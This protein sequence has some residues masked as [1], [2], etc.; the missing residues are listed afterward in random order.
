[1]T[2]APASA[3]W[4]YPDATVTS[5]SAARWR[6]E[7]R[8]CGGPL[9]RSALGAGR[10]HPPSEPRL[11]RVRLDGLPDG[12]VG[13]DLL[14]AAVDGRDLVA[15]VEGL[16]DTA[17]AALRHAAAA[18]DLHGIVRHKVG[19]PRDG[20]LQERDAPADLGGLRA[21]QVHLVRHLVQHR[22]AHLDAGEVLRQLLADNG[23][24]RQCLAEHLPLHGPF[25]DLLGADAGAR[26]APD[27]DHPALVVKVRHDDLE[28]LVLLDE[29]VPF[30]HHGALVGDEGS[31]CGAGVL[32]L[33]DLRLHRVVAL[34]QEHGDAPCAGAAG[35]HRGHEVV[36]VH[37]ASDPLLGAV[38]DVVLSRRVQHGGC[39]QGRDVAPS[40]RLADGQAARLLPAEDG[41]EE[42]VLHPRRAVLDDHRHADRVGRVH[43]VLPAWAHQADAFLLDHQLVEIIELLRRDHSTHE[44]MLRVLEMLAGPLAHGVDAHL[45]RLQ[46]E[47]RV[48]RRTISLACHGVLIH[49]LGPPLAK[50]FPKGDVGLFEVW[51]VHSL[52]VRG[53]SV[54]HGAE[55]FLLFGRR[56]QPMLEA[57]HVALHEARIL[58]QHLVPVQREEILR[59]VLA[60]V[61]QQRHPAAGVHLRELGDIVDG[62]VH[63]H[64]SILWGVV[65]LHLLQSEIRSHDAWKI[66]NNLRRTLACCK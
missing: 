33:D 65:L 61:V 9:V 47:V 36:R 37:A 46:S 5:A 60:R 52:Q 59:R 1:M 39:A 62:A 44:A 35:A 21:Q 12:E 63:D 49:V 54:W 25:E 13:H 19:H 57:N 18:Q 14:A 26:H 31:A 56:R 16:H 66:P 30:G 50:R 22:G 51:G 53:L 23:L 11:L 32:R 55:S 6:H 58:G 43:A 34:D 15:S 24:L 8:S 41:R 20:V 4:H 28:P 2:I 7:G 38:H 40:E 42:L 45:A 17:H 64:P 10:G 48:R 29:D 3:P 27:A